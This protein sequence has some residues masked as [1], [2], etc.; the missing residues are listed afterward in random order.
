MLE[1]ETFQQIFYHFT[2]I[3]YS[4]LLSKVEKDQQF[5]TCKSLSL[6]DTERKLEGSLARL[7]DIPVGLD[8]SQL[9]SGGLSCDYS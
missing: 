1:R 5:A 7:P 3:Q 6:S 9:F 4:A 2:T 8:S